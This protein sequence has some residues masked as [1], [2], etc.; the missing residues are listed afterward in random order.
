VTPR[1]RGGL[2]SALVTERPAVVTEGDIQDLLAKLD[3]ERAALLA[4]F[5]GMSEAESARRPPERTH[6]EDGWSVK[7]QLSHLAEMETTYRAWVQRATLET[8]PDLSSGTVRDQV[9]YPL[10]EAERHTV[11]A[12]RA[13]LEEQRERTL[14]VIDRLT[15]EELDCTA[16]SSFGELTVLQLLRSFYRHDRMHRDQIAGRTPEYQPR[17]RNGEPDQRRRV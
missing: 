17:W 2:Q 10:E 13:E 3:S 8:N 15:L 7:E 9:A 5:D 1:H 12:H 16:R 6:G 14:A 4:A 11:R